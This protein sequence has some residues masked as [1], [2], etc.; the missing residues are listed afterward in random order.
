M[1]KN[2][3]IKTN[4]S[5]Q[6]IWR[7]HF[8]AGLFC[9][10]FILWLSITGSIYLFKPQIDSY[11]DKPYS[12]F[13]VFNPASLSIQVY[14]ALKAMPDASF[15]A[16]Q[17]S[18]S[19][20]QATQILIDKK[21]KTYRV[22]VHP[23]SLEILKI[24]DEDERFTN[25]IANLHGELLLGNKGSILVELAASWTVVMLI[26][27]LFLWWPKG[28]KSLA[29]VLYPR[30]SRNGRTFWKDLHS[31][32]AFWVSFFAL[33]LILSGLPWAKSWGSMLK[34]LREVN[35]HTTIQPDWNIGHENQLEEKLF[36]HNHSNSPDAN[37]ENK[38]GYEILDVIVKEINYKS[39]EIPVLISPPDNKTKN[40]IVKSDSQNRLH[41]FK[42][43]MD[44][45][46]G[47]ILSREEFDQSPLI[48]RIVAIGVS[49]HEGQLFGWPNVA[50]GLFTAF[51]L[52]IA[53]ISAVIMWLARR[54]K[55]TIGAPAA[56]ISKSASISIVLTIIFLSLILPLLGVSLILVT[57]LE[58]AFL[59]KIPKIKLFLGL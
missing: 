56:N 18:E 41:R 8:Y 19:K 35:L 23:E 55:G 20:S 45:K 31:V 50:L 58:K 59:R 25:L 57:I 42:M 14:T 40:W 10:P 17:L 54:P 21:D 24:Q 28:S 30:V 38:L 12:H 34:E 51:G 52:V 9:I 16:Y 22:Y 48:D 27:G 33:F 29:G 39:N 2:T 36:H 49:A 32:I 13:E 47:R 43:E 46:T 26:T 4:A 15:N 5:Y 3:Q 11:I 37:S 1:S 6:M 44:A 7:W 53:S